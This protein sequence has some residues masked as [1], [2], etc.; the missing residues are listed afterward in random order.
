MADEQ[1]MRLPVALPVAC[2]GVNPGGLR[3]VATPQILGKWV[4]GGSLGSCRGLWGSWT[5]RKVLLYLIMN[6]KY[7]LKW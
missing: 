3:V 4:V 6:R 5:G 1:V 2:I 7:V